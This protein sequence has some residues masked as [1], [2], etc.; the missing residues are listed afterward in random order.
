MLRNRWDDEG[1][2]FA[3][4]AIVLRVCAGQRFGMTVPPSNDLAFLV[5]KEVARIAFETSGV[6]FIWDG[7]GEIHAMGTFVH[8]GSD[9]VSRQFRDVFLDP[10]SLIHQLIQRKVSAVRADESSFTLVFDDGQELAF[11]AAAL[12]ESGLIQL[13]AD[14]AEGWIVF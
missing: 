11:D 7:G 5:G 1:G 8:V 14:L 4:D 2:I 3:N 12:G 9:G 13:A 10:P 6:H